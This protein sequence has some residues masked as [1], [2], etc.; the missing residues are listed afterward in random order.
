MNGTVWPNCV[1]VPLRIYSVTH[2]IVNVLN[3]M[4]VRTVW[5]VSDMASDVLQVLGM[6]HD[7][8]YEE[9]QRL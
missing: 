6:W 5:C 2:D 9:L 7:S 1:D 3:I 8:Q 4:C